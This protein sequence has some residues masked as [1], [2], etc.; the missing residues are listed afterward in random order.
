MLVLL[1]ND[2]FKH[3]VIYRHFIYSVHHKLRYSKIILDSFNK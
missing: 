1:P 3:T 2:Y